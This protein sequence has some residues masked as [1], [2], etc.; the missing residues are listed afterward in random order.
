LVGRVTRSPHIG[1]IGHKIFKGP[2][3]ILPLPPLVGR[4]TRSVHML[5]EMD[6]KSLKDQNW[7]FLFTIGWK[8]DWECPHI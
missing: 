1:G 8:G 2:E 4:V 3:L 7:F 6:I 5:E